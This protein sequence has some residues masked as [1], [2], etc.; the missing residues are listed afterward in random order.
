[1]PICRIVNRF[2]IPQF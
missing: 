2:V 1:M